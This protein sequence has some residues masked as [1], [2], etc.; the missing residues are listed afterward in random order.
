[1]VSSLE[2][3]EGSTG[4]GSGTEGLG[5]VGG[6]SPRI[7]SSRYVDSRNA[8]TIVRLGR[9]VLALGGLAVMARG[10][11]WFAVVVDGE[12]TFELV[13]FNSV[14]GLGGRE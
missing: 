10:S 12:V 8:S 11:G 5:G 9:A 13:W 6:R 3:L 4:G 2:L 14:P 1:M 7:T